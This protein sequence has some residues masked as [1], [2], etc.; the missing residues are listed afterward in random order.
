VGAGNT[1]RPGQAALIALHLDASSGIPGSVLYV[2]ISIA[3]LIV[4]LAMAVHAWR[5]AREN[6][7]HAQWALLLAYCSLLVGPASQI[8]RQVDAWQD[9]A[10][11]AR[12][13]QRDSVENPLVLLAPDETTRAII[14]MYARPVVDRIEGPLDAAGVDRVRNI[15]GASPG[16]LFLVQLASQAPR[17]PWHA[18]PAQLDAPAPWQAANLE[19]AQRYSLPNGRRYALLRVIPQ[20]IA[21]TKNRIP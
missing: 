18:R 19:I 7:V 21:G 15:A 13:V 9:L 11:I 4:G 14:D 1:P 10:Q 8:Y 12:A 20:S 5:S 17:L 2:A 3:G 6:V 16:S